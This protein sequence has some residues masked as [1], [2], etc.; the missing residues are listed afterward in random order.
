MQIKL[1]NQ[2]R[3]NEVLAETVFTEEHLILIPEGTELKPE[4]IEL[5]ST[6]GVETVAIEDP[7]EKEE[8]PHFFISE[9][10]RTHYIEE[11]R[12]ILESH[13]YSGTDSLQKLDAFAKDIITDLKKLNAEQVFDYKTRNANLYEHT[14]MVAVLAVTI[15]KILSL[16]ENSLHEITI[17][18]LLH[19]IGLRYITVPYLNCAD[20]E[21]SAAELFEYKK[22]TILGF[23]A[24]EAE[25]WLPDLSRKMVL[26]HHERMDGSGFPLKQK[27]QDIGCRI[28]QVCD[29]FDCMITGMECKRVEIP[30]ALALLEKEKGKKYDAEIVT[31][32]EHIV[33]HYPVGT[34]IVKEDGSTFVVIE[35]KLDAARPRLLEIKEPQK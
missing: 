34:E 15:A 22:H 9:E 2:L 35:Q 14:V 32:L 20:A 4:Y 30:D 16:D 13:I 3:G 6:L 18:A 12:K 7:Y 33:A 28:L 1:V 5:L 11:T 8:T 27:R 24:L 25:S 10:Q 26:S 19:D 17:G 29:A 23:S 31:I 21:R